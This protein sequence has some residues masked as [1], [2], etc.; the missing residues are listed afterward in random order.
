MATLVAPSQ[1][2]S[3]KIFTS[4]LTAVA[5][6]LTIYRVIYRYVMHRFWWEDACA[7]VALTGSVICVVTSWT[8]FEL[9]G[10]PSVISFWIQALTSLSVVWSVR[11]SILLLIL[12]IMSPSRNLRRAM[13][14]IA[15]LFVLTWFSLMVAFVERCV[16]GHHCYT[17]S[18]QGDRENM[19]PVVIFELI[20]DILSDCTLIGLPIY[21]LHS[22]KLPLF[23][24]RFII[25]AFSSNILVIIICSFR[26][27]C[28]VLHISSLA[29]VVIEVEVACSL[30]VCNS[31]F[32]MTLVYRMLHR[33]TAIDAETSLPSSDQLTTVNLD[34]LDGF[35][36][37]ISGSI[38]AVTPSTTCPGGGME[39][40]KDNIP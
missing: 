6:V 23:Q 16:A 29:G 32:V 19:D 17:T 26:A 37:A 10:Q 15:G 7:V 12:R 40:H 9:A 36:S 30:F 14:F 20:T 3:L 4:T 27:A 22:V 31:L 24:R 35:V 33:N 18:S 34:A 8:H 5:L 2:R 11:L 13:I 21:S 38:P 39:K 28:Q 25:A 1:T